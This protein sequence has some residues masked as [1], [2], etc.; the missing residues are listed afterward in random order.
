MLK[1]MAEGIVGGNEEPRI[2][3]RFDHSALGTMGER[4]V[5]VGVVDRDRRAGLVGDARRARSVEHN[6]LVLC[7]GDVNRRKRGGRGGHIHQRVDML[8]LEPFARGSGSNVRLVL[9]IGG[10][11]FNRHAKHC[12]SEI[13]D[14]HLGRCNSAHAGDVC[15]DARHVL[16]HADL[17]DAVRNRG[18]FLCP[19]S[20]CGCKQ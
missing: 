3:P 6:D 9:V 10:N 13:L 8:V 4:I 14:R 15:I 5:V 12:S 2:V 20:E 1:I 17:H 16:D 7:F 18:L 19:H 11:D